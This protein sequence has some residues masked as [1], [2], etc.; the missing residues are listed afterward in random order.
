MDEIEQ[1][2][3]YLSDLQYDKAREI[4]E[5]LVESTAFVVPKCYACGSDQNVSAVRVHGIAGRWVCN[6]LCDI[7]KPEYGNS[8]AEAVAVFGK[9]G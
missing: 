2:I 5:R 4:L 7:S 9:K 6:C 3:Y 8:P 1:A